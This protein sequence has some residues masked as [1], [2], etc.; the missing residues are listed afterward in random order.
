MTSA[1]AGT[2]IS[3]RVPDSNAWISTTYLSV[4][5]SNSGSPFCP[6]SPPPLSQRPSVTPAGAPP[7]P[8]PSPAPDQPDA[9]LGDP[10]LVRDEGS[11]ERWR[12]RD[13]DI[14]GSEAPGGRVGEAERARQD[15]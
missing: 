4:S 1:P 8:R 12:E 13:G 11:L 15:A 5:T 2:R 3:I 7:P 14:G 9:R 6:V 10:L